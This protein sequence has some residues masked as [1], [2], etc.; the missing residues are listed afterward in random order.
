MTSPLTGAYTSEAALTDST[1]AAAAPCSGRAPGAGSSTKTRSPSCSCAWSVIPTVATSPSI[2]SHSWSSVNF[3]IAIDLCGSISVAFVAMRDERQIADLQRNVLSAYLAENPF[4][5]RCRGCVDVTHGDRRL[6]A[7]P[8]AAGRHGADRGCRNLVRVK[9]R[10]AAHRHAVLG[11]QSD[12]AAWRAVRQ[13]AQN[14]VCAGKSA[15]TR[16]PGAADF[17]DRPFERSHHRRRCWIEI[18]TV[19]TQP[20]F[21]PQAVARAKADRHHRIVLA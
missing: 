21:Q 18:G 5:G 3:N 4:T 17:R 15:R 8:K 20:S 13:L 19:E 6:H 7:R 11:L 2:R 12:A 9:F 1:T 16:S 14:D 10:A